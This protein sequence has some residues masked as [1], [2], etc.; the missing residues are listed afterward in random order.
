[1]GSSKLINGLKIGFSTV[2]RLTQL[3]FPSLTM[4]VLSSMHLYWYLDDPYRHNSEQIFTL[5]IY[6]ITFVD[7]LLILVIIPIF[8]NNIS[9]LTIFII[10]IIPIILNIIY[11]AYS[12]Q[13]IDF[14]PSYPSIGIGFHVITILIVLIWSGVPE[15][16]QKGIRGLLKRRKFLYGCMFIDKT[17]GYKSL[18]DVNS[19]GLVEIDKGDCYDLERNGDDSKRNVL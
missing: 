2:F 7:V 11:L 1:M 6:T 5:V 18:K 15:I 19:L 8:H 16:K 9:I 10:D 3:G 4:M 14:E 17:I 12:S 13:K